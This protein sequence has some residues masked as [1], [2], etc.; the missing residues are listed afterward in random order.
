MHTHMNMMCMGMCMHMHMHMHMLHMHMLHM[1]MH[2]HVCQSRLLPLWLSDS[3]RRG[4]HKLSCEKE[5][6]KRG[7]T[8]DTRGGMRGGKHTLTRETRG[9]HIGVWDSGGLKGEKRVDSI[10]GQITRSPSTFANVLRG[11]NEIRLTTQPGVNPA[12]PSVSLSSP[13][14]RV[15]SRRPDQSVGPGEL[16]TPE[17]G[18]RAGGASLHAA[19]MLQQIFEQTGCCASGPERDDGGVVWSSDGAPFAQPPRVVFLFV[20]GRL[21]VF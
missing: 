4:C 2:M 15:V 11:S 5:N 3:V 9:G 21:C 14:S 18:G 16:A 13:E 7:R 10:T 19:S 12:D 1:H 20:T 17:T 8:K 6:S